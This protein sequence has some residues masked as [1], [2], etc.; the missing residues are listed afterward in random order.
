MVIKQ[1]K[2]ER[3]IEVKKKHCTLTLTALLANGEFAVN[4]D[5]FLLFFLSIALED[6][7]TEQLCWNFSHM[8][9]EANQRHDFPPFAFSLQAF[10]G[11]RL[12]FKKREFFHFL[13]NA[14]KATNNT[15]EK[16]WLTLP[17]MLRLKPTHKHT[18]TQSLCIH[19]YWINHLK[20]EHS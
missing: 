8:L 18:H 15:E 20:L 5:C 7:K 9:Y 10:F 4:V 6:L 3:H 13:W 12:N 16:Q 11:K 14:S 17:K 2:I 19:Q 1:R